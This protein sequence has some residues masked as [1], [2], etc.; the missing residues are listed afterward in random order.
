MAIQAKTWGALP[1][2][3]GLLDQPAGLLNEM[4]AAWSVLVKVQEFDEL[5]AG[6]SADWVSK[7]QD[8]WPLIAEVLHGN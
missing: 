2:A 8:I 5:P 7:N 6:K 3:G 4:A 1:Y